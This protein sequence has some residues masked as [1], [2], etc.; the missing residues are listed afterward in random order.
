MCTEV[1]YYAKGLIRIRAFIGIDFDNECK[2]YIYGLQQKFRSYSVKGR[3]KYSGN[4]HL[5]LKFLAEITMDQKKSL[6]AALAEICASHSPFML[7]ISEIGIFPGKGLVRVLWLGLGGDTNAL[8]KLAAEIDNCTS[9]LGFPAEAR[10]Y[11]PHITIGQDVVFDR[12]FDE[13]KTLVGNPSWGP[14]MVNS[15]ELFRSE[16]IG[17]KRVYT[18]I[19]EYGLK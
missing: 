6:D 17:N 15:V 2:K 11:T 12:P 18:K 13:I 3:W 4:F 8:G 19:S 9:S 7:D 5:T 10:R 14:V 16:Q 1:Q